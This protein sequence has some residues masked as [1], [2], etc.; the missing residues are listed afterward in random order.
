[1]GYCYADHLDSHLASKGL[2]KLAT[3]Q[4]DANF[5]A[6]YQKMF[7]DPNGIIEQVE[8]D[9]TVG[10]LSYS[11]SLLFVANYFAHEATPLL[12]EPSKIWVEV[13]GQIAQAKIRAAVGDT[14]LLKSDKFTALVSLMSQALT[15]AY[16]Q[17]HDNNGQGFLRP[18][19]PG[20][21]LKPLAGMD[22]P[23]DVKK[24]IEKL[25]IQNLQL[26]DWK[27]YGEVMV[28]LWDDVAAKY[29]GAVRSQAKVETVH[30]E[31]Q[32]IFDPQSPPPPPL[33]TTTTGQG[34]KDW[35]SKGEQI[36]HE[37]MTV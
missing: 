16:A 17:T 24:E 23:E 15:I 26:G 10:D 8:H 18:P 1:M 3:L 9:L 11:A 20:E 7:L 35:L 5:V 32:V 25:Q 14:V 12:H 36:H 31:P 34:V 4:Q 29:N 28:S 21:I 19:A 2:P 6:Q 22:V 33:I 37:S 27:A 30:Y 13:F